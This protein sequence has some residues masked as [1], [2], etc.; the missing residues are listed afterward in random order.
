MNNRT[1]CG[2]DE[3]DANNGKSKPKLLDLLTNEIRVLHYSI[4]TEHT[5]CD[6]VRRYC[7][8]HHY[9]H[10]REMGAEQINQFLTYLAVERVKGSAAWRAALACGL[11]PRAALGA[12]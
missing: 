4:R 12:M 3:D 11:T 7:K 6:W 10:P 8:Y 5:Y 9:T 1:T 2:Y